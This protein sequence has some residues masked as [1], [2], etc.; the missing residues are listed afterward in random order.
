MAF[1]RE[2]LLDLPREQLLR[3]LLDVIAVVLRLWTTRRLERV[4]GVFYVVELVLLLI[5]A[6]CSVVLD[7]AAVLLL[8]LLLLIVLLVLMMMKLVLVLQRVVP[9]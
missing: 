1:L 2:C 4:R 7:A 8:L 9:S 3:R 5:V 6:V